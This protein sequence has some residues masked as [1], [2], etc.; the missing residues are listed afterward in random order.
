MLLAVSARACHES[1]LLK[2][3]AKKG[4]FL[5]AYHWHHPGSTGQNLFVFNKN[6]GEIE[7]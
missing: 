7:E 4:I 2:G 3:L 6:R 1:Q 5:K